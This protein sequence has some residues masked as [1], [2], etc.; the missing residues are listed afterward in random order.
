[1]LSLGEIAELIKKHQ[2]LKSYREVADD[3]K[4]EYKKFN[5]WRSRKGLPYDAIEALTTYCNR[6][7]LNLNFFLTGEGHP[8]VP[9]SFAAPAEAG[10]MIPVIAVADAGRGIES[11]DQGY[12][13][14]FSDEY[15]SR[16]H[17]LTDANAYCIRVAKEAYSME[18]VLRPGM[19]CIA[20]PNLECQNGDMAVVKTK[21]FDTT[22][23][24]VYFKGSQV[25]L[26]SY[27]PD[28][29]DILIERK[30]LILC[31]PIVWWRRPK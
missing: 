27:S 17:G 20:S 25:T 12:P 7:N 30:D 16:P 5:V 23:K 22:I 24:L 19:L 1:M 14:G 15:V 11:T 21:N 29:E 9:G 6:N 18:P 4:V 31:H 10:P 8:E 13:Q 28:Q 26:K 3:L 2:G